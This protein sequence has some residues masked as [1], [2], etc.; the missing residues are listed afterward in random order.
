MKDAKNTVV[1]T[2]KTEKSIERET[3]ILTMPLSVE[4]TYVADRMKSQPKS[5]EE[6]FTMEDKR[7]APHEHRLSL[8]KEL[9]AYEKKFCFRWINKRKRAVDEAVDIKGW[10]IANKVLFP[11]VPKHLFSMSGAIERGDAILGFMPLKKAEAIRKAPG[12]KSSDLV[13]SQLSKGTIPLPKGKSGFYKP[14][15]TSA[16]NETDEG[17]PTG[18]VMEGRDF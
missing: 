17:I 3:P 4:D 10:V 2:E 9:K 11:D 8:P 18:G 6:V 14:E 13:K 12:D 16:E 15:D 7:Y 1:K 5:L